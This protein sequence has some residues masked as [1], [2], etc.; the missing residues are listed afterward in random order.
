[1]KVSWLVSYL[2]I[3]ITGV[4]SVCACVGPSA[5]YTAVPGVGHTLMKTVP[6][7]A[8]VRFSGE[9]KL[10][11]E[12][13]VEEWNYV[14]NGYE[15]LEV[16]DWKFDMEIGKLVEAGRNGGLLILKIDSSSDL[17]PDD[18]IG[19]K[20]VAWTNKIGGRKIFMI[21]DRIYG[22]GRFHDALLHEEGHAM[23]ADHIDGKSSLMATVYS[24]SNAACVDQWTARA[25]AEYQMIPFS[26]MNWCYYGDFYRPEDDLK[27]KVNLRVD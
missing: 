20:T 16:V 13:T 6:V 27:Y 1:M 25:V 8:D 23:G 24:R 17:V 12:Q 15:K 11:I 4:L 21:R 7:Y 9:D 26:G 22:E 18:E 3:L 10:V 14:L 19:Y 5:H 2:L